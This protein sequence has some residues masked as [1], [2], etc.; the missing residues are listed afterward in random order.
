MVAAAAVVDVGLEVEALVDDAVA[1]VVDAV[2][3]LDAAV[4][5]LALAAV[6]GI[7]V[8]VDEVADAGELARAGH[9]V[10]RR[11]RRRAVVE[12]R[13]AVERVGLAIGRGRIAQ[14]DARAAG[15]ARARVAARAA[16]AVPPLPATP[17]TSG[18]ESGSG[19]RLERACRVGRVAAPASMRLEHAAE[20]VEAVLAP[21]ARTT[22]A[23][24]AASPS[25]AMRRWR[26]D[27]T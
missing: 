10:G 27:A 13:A 7:L 22:A 20:V 26:K 9:A 5:R 8:G 23:M 15:A 16:A 17:V 19:R 24:S 12:A 2:A 18:P 21:A 4:R 1:V 11:V 14:H 6:R 25:G 3:G